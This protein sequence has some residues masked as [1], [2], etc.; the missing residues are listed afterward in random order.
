MK[1]IERKTIAQLCQDIPLVS[2]PFKK[3][4]ERVGM[5]EDELIGLLLV[6]KEEKTIRRFGVKLKH[7]KTGYRYNAMSVWN[8]PE[9]KV[10][11]A[12]KIM[13]SFKE[14]S[15][16]YVRPTYPDWHY[17]LFAMIHGK[18][19]SECERVAG[20]I[21]KEISINEYQM[22]YS[23]REFKKTDMVYKDRFNRIKKGGVI[24]RWVNI[25]Y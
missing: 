11:G 2:R 1:E 24:R 3:V 8:V 16:C 4:A 7:R 19:K 15:H 18:T 5:S 25:P 20:E 23:Q 6:W 13:A 17:N 22:L 21:A 10:T 12:G 14:V 9:K